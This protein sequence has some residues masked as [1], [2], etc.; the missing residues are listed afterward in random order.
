MS[1]FVRNFQ[2]KGRHSRWNF[3]PIMKN[4]IKDQLR[5]LIMVVVVPP[6]VPVLL[7]WFRFLDVACEWVKVWWSFRSKC[8]H[9]ALFG[10]RSEHET[11]DR[12][13]YILQC[14]RESI[15]LISSPLRSLWV[16]HKQSISP[17]HPR[18]V[19]LVYYSLFDEGCHIL[20][21]DKRVQVPFKISL[22][23]N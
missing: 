14:L 12:K 2:V 20:R 5:N 9:K 6:I 4:P 19:S 17:L 1:E 16:F 8:Y 11:L 13:S 21:T 15:L 7:K 23:D 22:D 18:Y 10:R 3:Q